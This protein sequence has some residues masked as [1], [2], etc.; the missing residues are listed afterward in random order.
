MKLK[1]ALFTMTLAA[2]P[3]FAMHAARLEASRTVP[4]ANGET[5]YVFKD[6]L[7]AKEGRF[8]RAIYLRPGEV[9]VSAD[10]QQITA[11]GNEVARLASLLRKDHKN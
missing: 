3:V 11:V 1:I 10:G 7:M 4:L 9:V 5:L 2:A 8:G 6:G